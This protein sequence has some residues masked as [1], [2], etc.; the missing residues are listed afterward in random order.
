MTDV[1][2]VRIADIAPFAYAFEGPI[3][4]RMTDIGRTLG[5]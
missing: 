4:A 5:A 2:H 1:R 3:Q